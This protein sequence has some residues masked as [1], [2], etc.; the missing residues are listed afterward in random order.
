MPCSVAVK[1]RS[2]TT[3]TPPNGSPGTFVGP[4]DATGGGVDRHHLA[5][6]LAGLGTE[7]RGGVRLEGDRGVDGRDV[8][9]AVGGGRRRDDPTERAGATRVG[10]D[11]SV[12]S[13]FS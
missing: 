10:P 4:R 1:T 13:S 7:V 9:D 12:S 2:F 3:T 5:V 8:D 11:S 6:E